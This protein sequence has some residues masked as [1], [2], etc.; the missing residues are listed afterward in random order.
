[1]VTHVVVLLIQHNNKLVECNQ[2]LS[3]DAESRK[4]RVLESRRGPGL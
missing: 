3:L 2:T 1:M 4:L